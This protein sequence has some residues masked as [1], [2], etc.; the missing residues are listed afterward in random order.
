MQHHMQLTCM[1]GLALFSFKSFRSSVLLFVFVTS[2]LISKTGRIYTF[3]ENLNCSFQT[4]ICS[5]S[6]LGSNKKSSFSKGAGRKIMNFFAKTALRKTDSIKRRRSSDDRATDCDRK[7]AGSMLE[8]GISSLCLWE[9][10]LTQIAYLGQAAY[11]SW[12]PC[13]TEDLQTKPQE[14]RPALVW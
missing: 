14:G 12:P 6:N 2:C 5:I 8:S 13:P 1:K 4:I 9:R 7:V 3:L 10:H 11:S